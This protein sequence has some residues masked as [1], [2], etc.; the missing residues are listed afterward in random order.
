[1]LFL[2]KK[3]SIFTKITF[4]LLFSSKDDFKE[5]RQDF[6]FLTVSVLLCQETTLEVWDQNL[7]FF[8][9]ICPC[10]RTVENHTNNINQSLWCFRGTQIAY[11]AQKPWI[12]N[13]SLRNN[14][15]AGQPFVWKK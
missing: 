2:N 6:A 1:M 8:S 3:I 5:D 9:K 12:L 14:I 10:P 13:T 7:Y 15:L 11:V 4:F